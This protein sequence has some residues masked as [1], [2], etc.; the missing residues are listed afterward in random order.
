MINIPEDLEKILK[1]ASLAPSSHNCQP[2]EVQMLAEN[3]LLVRVDPARRLTEVDGENREMMLSMG[4]FWENLELAAHTLGYET[5]IKVPAEHNG[6]TDIL[7][8]RLIK[9][10]EPQLSGGGAAVLKTMEIRATNRGK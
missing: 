7:E 8:I 6:A 2:W 10:R 9:R 3:Q 4:A 5:R 1:Y